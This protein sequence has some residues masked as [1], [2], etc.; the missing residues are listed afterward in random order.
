M[1]V[2]RFE[3]K[4]QIPNTLIWTAVIS[5]VL[6]LMLFGFYPIFLDSRRVVEEMLS[7]FPA[8][9]AAAFGFDLDDLFGYTSFSGMI[10]LYESLLGAI[11][12]AGTALAVFARE[13]QNKCADF[14]LTKPVS[15]GSV[16]FQ[17]LLCCLTLLL[18]INIPY[19]ALFAAGYFHYTGAALNGQVV[20]CALCLL[21]TQFVFTAFGIFA[22]T[23]LRRVRSA[24]GLGAGI[25]L[26]ALLLSM[27][28][29]LTEKEFFKFISPL[30]YFSP[31]TVAEKGGYD[32]ACA[33]TAIILM[34]GMSV[35]AYIRYTKSDVAA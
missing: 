14:L 12:A 31:N 28:Y 23:F 27:L 24:S 8:G 4:R 3:L 7:A 9:F 16:F 35:A 20:L 26:F 32:I 13:K 22:A 2:Y 33:V 1:Q 29:S 21:L 6:W 34:L 10:Y 17:K 19:L 5:A 30:F 18:I 11:M 25:G 15:R